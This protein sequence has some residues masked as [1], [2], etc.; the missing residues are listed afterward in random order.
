MGA[1][2]T[3]THLTRILIAGLITGADHLVVYFDVYSSLSV[4]DFAL[5]IINHRYIDVL[6]N[7]GSQFGA[8]GEAENKK[9]KF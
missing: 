1:H 9:K 5:H 4:P 6:Q 7:F 8:C 3:S 2:S